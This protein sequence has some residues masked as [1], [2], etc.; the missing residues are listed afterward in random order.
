[1]KPENALTKLALMLLLPV[2]LLSGCATPLPPPAPQAAKIPPLPPQAQ[3][4]TPPPICS[5]N[6]SAGLTTLR[7]KLLDSLIKHTQPGEP[8]S[9]HGK[10]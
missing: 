6:C 3:Q 10:N 8:A 2:V 5:P 9:A 7:T 1:M 4:P